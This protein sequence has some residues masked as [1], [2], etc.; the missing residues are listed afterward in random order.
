MLIIL[1]KVAQQ[2]QNNKRFPL[3]KNN[4]SLTVKSLIFYGMRPFN[5]YKG[6]KGIRQ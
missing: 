2:L 6:S 5:F 4:K 3:K 1:P